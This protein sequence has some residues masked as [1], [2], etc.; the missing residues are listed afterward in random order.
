M[1]ALDNL[2]VVVEIV[3]SVVDKEVVATRSN[4]DAIERERE[5]EPTKDTGKLTDPLMSA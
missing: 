5:R 4:S 2:V 1:V 3:A